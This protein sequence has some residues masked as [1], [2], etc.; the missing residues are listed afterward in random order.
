VHEFV[1]I[2][3]HHRADDF[4]TERPRTGAGRVDAARPR[5]VSSHVDSAT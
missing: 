3:G 4:E 1:D 2:I 5:N